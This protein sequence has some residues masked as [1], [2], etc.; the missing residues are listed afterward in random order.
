MVCTRIL[1]VLWLTGFCC[2]KCGTECSLNRTKCEKLMVCL[3]VTMMGNWFERSLGSYRFWIFLVALVYFLYAVYF[4]IYGLSF[5]VGLLSDHYV[6]DHV[7]QDPWWWAILYYGS[8]GVFGF[9]SGFFRA[10]AGVFAVYASFVFWRKNVEL[11]SIRQHVSKV[12]LFEATYFISLSM[13]VVASLTYYFSGS[14]FYYFDGL[15]GLIFVLVAG[16]PLL[17][18]IVCVSPTVLTLRKKIIRNAGEKEITKWAC[19]TGVAYLFVVFWFNLSMSWAGSMVPHPRIQYGLSF[20]LSPANLVS[21]VLTFVGLLLLAFCGVIICWPAIQKK[22]IQ[23]S[24]KHVG[25]I[26][27]ALGGYFILNVLFYYGTGGY[28]A[29]PSVWYEVIGPLHNPSLWCIALLFLG[30]VVALRS[31]T[32]E[33]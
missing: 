12:L 26:L 27:I 30:L 21:F 2:S 9:L 25:A 17:A 10:V 8:E 6:F 18:M 4:A 29:N 32:S 33:M 22:S 7:S 31:N 20:L 5:S 11:S 19:L 15:P 23:L 13:S 14:K 24:L 16:L 3:K 28:H 1:I